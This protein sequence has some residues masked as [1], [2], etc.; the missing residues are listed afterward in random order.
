MGAAPSHHH[1][2]P[3]ALESL[4]EERER[5]RDRR[6]QDQGDSIDWGE[7]DRKDPLDDHANDLD[8]ARRPP[9]I[10]SIREAK[11]RSAK[12]RAGGEGSAPEAVGH[13]MSRQCNPFAPRSLMD[14]RHQ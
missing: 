14:R 1:H 11:A 13:A 3:P 10:E 4:Q 5:R 7:E 6:I 12:N 2:L 9:E 8:A